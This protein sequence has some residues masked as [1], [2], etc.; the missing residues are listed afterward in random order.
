MTDVHD[1]IELMKAPGAKF[2]ALFDPFTRLH[3]QI[4]VPESSDQLRDAVSVWPSGKVAIIPGRRLYD[5]MVAKKVP[6]R[7][8]WHVWIWHRIVMGFRFRSLA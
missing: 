1:A 5:V 4:L 3:Q 7:Y 6:W 8:C 2:A